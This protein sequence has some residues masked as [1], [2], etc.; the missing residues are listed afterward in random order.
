MVGKLLK[1]ALLQ[2]NSDVSGLCCISWTEA[3]DLSSS[4]YS[5]GLY[6]ENS[7]VPLIVKSQAVQLHHR[8]CRCEEEV[9]RLK[10]EMHNC[11][12]YYVDMYE[13]F[14]KCTEKLQH[15]ED[16]LVPSRICLLK[17]EKTH[18]SY[19]AVEVI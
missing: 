8:I 17:K 10:T 19:Q 9:T 11:V 13:Y 5:D 7:I 2:Y 4:F 15:S 1:K 12:N 3:V 18:C 16:Q 6:C 14:T